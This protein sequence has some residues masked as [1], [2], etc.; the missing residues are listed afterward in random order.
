MKHGKASMTAMGAAAFRAVES[1]KNE[2][3]RVCFDPYAEFFLSPPLR[4][5]SKSSFLTRIAIFYLNV[6]L[7]G[8]YNEIVSRTRYIDDR[9]IKSI[10]D[11]MTQLVIMGAGYDTR[12]H[13][14]RQVKQKM[15][16]F[17]IDHPDTQRLK[18]KR[19][20][21]LFNGKSDHVVYVPVDFERQTIRERLAE[22]GYDS[23][24]KTL[25]IWEGVTMYISPDAVDETLAFVAGHS[26]E[27]SGII[28]NYCFQSVVDGSCTLFGAEKFR[29]YVMKKEEPILFGI[30]TGMTETFLK[31]RG[32]ARVIDADGKGLAEKY[33]TGPNKGRRNPEFGGIVYAVV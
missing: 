28:F 17:E 13:R 32:F 27:G 24:Q 11:G 21:Q 25:F 15:R 16:V 18:I 20:D 23:S 33:F 6:K 12:A 26:A 7:P 14:I 5:I 10:D 8:I 29:K 30:E 22:C 9:V 1:M 2:D 19:I 3:Q 4:K 31:Q